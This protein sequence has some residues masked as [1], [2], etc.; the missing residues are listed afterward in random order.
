MTW[1][2]LGLAL[3][4]AL[5][6][7]LIYWQL[8]LAE[9]AYLGPRVVAWTYDLVARRYDTIKQFKPREESWFLAKPLLHQLIGVTKPLVLDV[10]TGTGRLP[11]ALIR[12]H[13]SGQIVGLDLSLGMLRQA[14]AKLRPY[15][16]QVCLVWQDA[17]HLPFDDKTFDAVT[18]LE[19]LEFLPHPVEAVAEMLR[20]LVPGGVLLLSNRVGGEA[21]LLPRRAISR[22]MFEKL[23]AGRD[24]G[25][26]CDVDVRPWQVSYDLAVAR[27]AGPPRTG[28]R[29]A[30]EFGQVVRCPRCGGRLQSHPASR[31]APWSGPAHGQL[32]CNSCHRAYPIREGI[33]RL[34]GLREP[35]GN[36]RS[37]D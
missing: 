24:L 4:V 12:E 7:A 2:Y 34:A 28:G 13:F 8:I 10:A 3:G 29:S 32:S 20:V 17:S 1:L 6:A 5:L 16:D 15:G 23:L 18:C 30:G 11:L 37:I 33:V 22:P 19:S 14:R 25:P 36:G 31:Q 26:L 21:R 35:K 27:K 9:G